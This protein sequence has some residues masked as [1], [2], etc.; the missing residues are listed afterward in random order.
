MFYGCISLVS[1][2]I[3]NFNTKNIWEYNQTFKDC[4]NL[5]YIDL[6][7]YF[8][9]D[10]FKS[11]SNFTIL[12]I[13]IKSFEQINNGKNI[14]FEKGVRNK[15]DIITTII[16][17]IPFYTTYISTN[18]EAISNKFSSTL[19]N[20]NI[21]SSSSTLNTHLSFSTSISLNS[22]S[23]QSSNLNT[24]EISNNSI[25]IS[26]NQEIESSI[27]G[28]SNPQEKETNAT[29]STI[30]KVSGTSIIEKNIPSDIKKKST[31]QVTEATMLTSTSTET[32]L[33]DST[34]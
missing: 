21:D 29:I 11:I 13:C 26:T 24:I 19:I 15:F 25:Q 14:L 33:I 30:I 9:K 1:L 32:E 17:S 2:D 5:V 12:T 27:I 6:Y 4:N 16:T 8:G 20:S 10:I 18:I 3:S 22:Q 31:N 23:I 28:K 7:H 34:S